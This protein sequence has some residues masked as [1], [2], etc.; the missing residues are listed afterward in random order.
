MPFPR[1]KPGPVEFWLAAAFTEFVNG[2][3]EGWGGGGMA[4]AG[5][6]AITGTTALGQDMSALNQVLISGG[7]VVLSMVGHGLQSVYVWHKTNR[8]PNP[9]P[10]STGN[11][12]PPIPPA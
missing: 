10:A 8:F 1:Y 4:G 7:A 12:T 5:T 2:F 6:G 9:W 11:T 3:I